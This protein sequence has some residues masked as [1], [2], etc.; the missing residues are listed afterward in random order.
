MSRSEPTALRQGALLLLLLTELTACS[1]VTS[2]G[3]AIATQ[4]HSGARAGEVVR[5]PLGPPLLDQPQGRPACAVRGSPGLVL[6]SGEAG[7]GWWRILSADGCVGWMEAPLS[8]LGRARVFTPRPV[9][10][11]RESHDGEAFFESAWTPEA[12]LE[13]SD[14]LAVSRSRRPAS[15][16]QLA[17]PAYANPYLVPWLQVASPLGTF[18][19]PASVVQFRWGQAATQDGAR[20]QEALGAAGLEGLVRAPFL[21]PVS[22]LLA[23]YAPQGALALAVLS[24]QQG[25]PRSPPLAMM[26]RLAEEELL[27]FRDGRG[28]VSST[29]LGRSTDAPALLSDFSG[30]DLDGNE[31]PDLLLEVTSLSGDGW[32]SELLAVSGGQPPRLLASLPLGSESGEESAV[33]WTGAWWPEDAAPGAGARVWRVRSS[34]EGLEVWRHRLAG[35]SR[36]TERLEDW[37]GVL[38]ETGSEEDARA[39]ALSLSTRL[40]Q[41]VAVFFLGQGEGE[42]W[43]Y[44]RLFATPEQAHAWS[45]LAQPFDSSLRSIDAAEL[46]RR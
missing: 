27:V 39:R 7:R 28:S 46:R 2:R 13:G 29:R 33:H 19:L 43:G 10:G 35:A 21:A 42:R 22:G 26:F 15:N 41:R 8:A 17:F 11:S 23:R 3:P 18:W 20:L 14:V 45:G 44:G 30:V 34:S 12:P 37:E 25:G 5:L 36:E 24:L 32:M 9:S 4:V 6:A 40:G 31:D 1:R 38:A 16:V